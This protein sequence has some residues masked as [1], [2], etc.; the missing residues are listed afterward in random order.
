[1]SKER[2][3]AQKRAVQKYKREKVHRIYVEFYGPDSDILEH[4]QKQEKKQTYIK[5]LIRADMQ[6]GES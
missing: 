6:K 2:S 5:N 1:M 3:E 4:I